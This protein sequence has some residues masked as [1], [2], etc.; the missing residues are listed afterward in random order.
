MAKIS[1]LFIYPVKSCKG[2]AVDSAIATP[3][4]F[5]YDRNWMIVDGKNRFMTQRSH[6]QMSQIECA[7]NDECLTMTFGG[8]SFDIPFATDGETGGEIIDSAVF[9]NKVQG[10]RQNIAGLESHLSEFL[11]PDA[12][13][14]RF[15]G[16][17][18]VDRDYVDAHLTYADNFPYTIAD[19][20]DF[21]GLNT[22]F[23]VKGL[24]EVKIDRFRSNIIL[25]G[26][27][28]DVGS[29]YRKFIIE[30]ASETI[31]GDFCEPCRRCSMPEINQQTGEMTNHRMQRSLKDFRGGVK[32]DWFSTH[33]KLNITDEVEISVD[34]TLSF[35]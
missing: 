32:I 16:H 28:P 11:A 6:Q 22:Y 18:K 23:T 20:A 30:T 5:K 17:R 35:Q 8:K 1:K 9:R 14:I 21:D 15:A 34:D 29:N 13:L 3:A 12:K 27:V 10:I 26:A 4:G 33:S 7:L 24:P 31:D 25:S 19:M 2:I